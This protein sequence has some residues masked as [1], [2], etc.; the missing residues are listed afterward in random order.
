MKILA[1]L[2]FLIIFGSFSFL[3]CS[4]PLEN[5]LRKLEQVSAVDAEIEQGDAEAQHQLE[6]NKKPAAAA[7]ADAKP[8]KTKLRSPDS[9]QTAEVIEEADDAAP[10]A[11]NLEPE[12]EEPTPVEATEEV[13]PEDQALAEAET[14]DEDEVAQAP[15]NITGAYL[16]CA[17][18]ETEVSF[19]TDK[20]GC[21]V[22][23]EDAG[24]DKITPTAVETWTWTADPP[25][26]V[27]AE[28]VPVPDEEDSEWSV[29]INYSDDEALNPIA[30]KDSTVSVVIETNA[31]DTT[32]IKDTIEAALK[33]L[34]QKRYVRVLWDSIHMPKKEAANPLTFKNMEILV[35]GQWHKVNYG[36]MTQLARE[37][38][39][40]PYKGKILGSENDFN[41]QKYSAGYS[42]FN[43]RYTASFSAEAPFDH[44]GET[45]PGIMFDFGKPVSASGMRFE[46]G[47]PIGDRELAKGLAD[48]IHLEVSDDGVNWTLVPGSELSFDAFR[49]A[50]NFEWA[51]PK[52]SRKR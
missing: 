21:R 15:N 51:K 50:M 29:I 22:A 46:G 41:L 16:T 2:K 18:A 39:V 19:T 6:T 44:I 24:Q 33:G 34:E 52:K 38:T 32:E 25:E 45:Q 23:N 35:D 3:A 11:E 1:P 42:R 48:F 27:K 26:G 17:Y 7:A 5:D 28:V 47:K 31:G 37:I 13:L 30:L 36:I 40:G 49:D 4:E 43:K 10:A 20:V 9:D 8:A 14:A 12:Q